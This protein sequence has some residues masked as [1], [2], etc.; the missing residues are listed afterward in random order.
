MGWYQ[1]RVL[2]FFFFFFFYFLQFIYFYTAKT[3]NS[4][5]DDTIEMNFPKS[6]DVTKASFLFLLL[7]DVISIQVIASIPKIQISFVTAICLGRIKSE[8]NVEQNSCASAHLIKRSEVFSEQCLLFLF[9]LLFFFLLFFFF[10]IILLCWCFLTTI[11]LTLWGLSIT[12]LLAGPLTEPLRKFLSVVISS[13][14]SSSLILGVHA[15]HWWVLSNESLWVKTLLQGLLSEL[16]LLPLL[17][18]LQVKFLGKS[19]LFII[20]LVS[21]KLNNNVEDLSSLSLEFIGVHG[22]NLKG[23]QSDAKGNLLLFFKLFLGLCHFSAGISTGSTSNRLLLV[24]SSSS[25]LGF[26]HFFPCGFSFFKLLLL[27][28]SFLGL[29]FVLFLSEFLLL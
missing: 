26:K 5:I 16:S 1:R 17:Q 13:G 10:I 15:D 18:F 29:L 6:I 22:I 8:R 3:E 2:F 19:S 25:L 28:F 9:F 4:I 7:K 27:F 23:L 24:C 14:V 12:S 11:L 20:I 21:L